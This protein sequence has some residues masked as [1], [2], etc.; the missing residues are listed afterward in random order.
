M[1]VGAVGVQRLG[2]TGGVFAVLAGVVALRLASR[3]GAVPVCTAVDPTA[4]TARDAVALGG[5]APG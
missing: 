4:G 2:V 3:L 5:P 1:A